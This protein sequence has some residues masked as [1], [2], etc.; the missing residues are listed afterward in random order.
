M[1]MPSRLAAYSMAIVL[2][3]VAQLQAQGPTPPS[4]PIPQSQ[5]ATDRPSAP[6]VETLPM[7]REIVIQQVQ[8]EVTQP[9]APPPPA[10][11]PPISQ[12]ADAAKDKEDCF[13]NKL[14]GDHSRYRYLY[15]Q[16]GGFGIQDLEFGDDWDSCWWRLP[17]ATDWMN[18]GGSLGFSI[19]WWDGPKPH[20][21]EPVLD[22]PPRVYDLYCNFYWL[23][24]VA[25]WLSFDFMVSPGLYGDFDTTP[26]QAFRLK[27]HA[28]GIISLDYDFH[29]V[30]GFDYL[31]RDTI[32]ALPVLGVLWEPE[33]GVQFQLVYPRP[34]VSMLL[35]EHGQNRWWGYVGGEF[36]GGA[37]AYKTAEGS[38][39]TV[40]YNDLRVVA[41]IELATLPFQTAR[42]HLE[43]GYV[44]DRA[45][46]SKDG[47]PDFD[48]RDT[49][50]VSLWFSY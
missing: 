44:F 35:G 22:L 36:G 38:H 18:F 30:A 16:R 24:R 21:M 48:P 34:R 6:T 27:G 10:P 45:I 11:P 17:H 12:P 31:N 32:D 5:F 2:A 46:N 41:G 23:Q 20:G 14:I 25:D 7:P 3:G 8:L 49:W 28:V 13:A 40:E 19:H 47:R 43:F 1:P 42:A 39:T 4:P 33:P 9:A 37:W 26:T 15:P 29:L 50:L